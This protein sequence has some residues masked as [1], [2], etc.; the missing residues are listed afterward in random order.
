MDS[1]SVERE[2][3]RIVV[4][5]GG[6]RSL[7]GP[8][9]DALLAELTAVAERTHQPSPPEAGV[10][11]LQ[12]SP[13]NDVDDAALREQI[14]TCLLEDVARAFDDLRWLLFLIRQSPV[15][16]TFASAH[17]CLGSAFELALSCQKRLWFSPEARLG[18]PAIAAG[19]YPPGGII[20]DL[21]KRAGKTRDV[22]QAKP[23]LTAAEARVDGT[24]DFCS[25]AGDWQ[26]EAAS[27]FE[28]LHEERERGGRRAP[29]RAPRIDFST[30]RDAEARQ[31][32]FESL[33]FLDKSVK[34]SPVLPKSAWEICWELVKERA[35]LKDPRDLGRLVAYV[36]ARH[37]LS[38]D[39]QAWTAQQRAARRA[40][41]PAFVNARPPARVVIDLDY[42]A[43]P[44]EI[45]C[46]MLKN[47]TQ[48]TFV[49]AES[50]AL[51]VAVN[52]VFNRLERALGA[53]PAQKAWERL[54]SWY[55][56]AP[57]E[58]LLRWT[59][60]D[61]VS[62][63]AAGRTVSLL[64]LAGNASGAEPGYLEWPGGEPEELAGALPDEILAVM[65]LL[66]DGV[67]TTPNRGVPRSVHVRSLFL[68]ELVRIARYVE[69]DLGAVV[70]ALSAKG[71]GFAGSDDAWDR[72]LNTRRDAYRPNL[73]SALAG[74]G[75]PELDRANWEIGTFKHARVLA[76]KAPAEAGVRWNPTGVSQHMA[77]FLGLVVDLVAKDGVRRADADGFCALALGFPATF[78]SPSVFLKRHG[79]R[80]VEH[81]ASRYWPNFRFDHSWKEGGD[82]DDF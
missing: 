15:P 43:P 70:D 21:N 20:E 51:G 37:A 2:E 55:Q 25:R 49:G 1:I 63:A 6:R 52:L 5:I 23:M 53:D 12:E 72:F 4:R 24:I 11:I 73:A 28:L 80:R 62:I 45:V 42:L 76:K 27:F 64:R 36:A 81:Y 61:R 44:T 16:W 8:T 31:G 30:P 7:Y 65:R 35:K 34:A 18:F 66:A 67:M 38:P 10:L 68:E 71:W 48:I 75:A 22:W 82:D 57:A 46:R 9:A 41:P 60:D 79:R 47:E 74:F 33:E 14:E 3:R 17:D 40:R 59:I 19:F 13:L 69:G 29:N 77:M 26:R 56:G 78:G 58:P 39:F 54:V 32:A 50:D